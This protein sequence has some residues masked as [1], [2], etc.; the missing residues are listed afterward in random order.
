MTL[1]G[2]A[3]TLALPPTE[4]ATPSGKIFK[5][6][7]TGGSCGSNNLTVDGGD[8]N[9]NGSATG[10]LTADYESWTLRF[11]GTEYNLI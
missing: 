7:D 9:I 2:G 10:T 8:Y 6:I 4:D 5:I 11:N 3:F 1:R